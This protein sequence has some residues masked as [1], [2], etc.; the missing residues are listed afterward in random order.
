MQFA[1][2]QQTFKHLQAHAPFGKHD[3]LCGAESTHASNRTPAEAL[4]NETERCKQLGAR[5]DE[6]AVLD[7]CPPKTLAHIVNG[8]F[9]G[10]CRENNVRLSFGC[11]I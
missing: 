6:G 2:T 4:L 10:T 8:C 9:A 11:A 1:L 5:D 3:Y 7:G